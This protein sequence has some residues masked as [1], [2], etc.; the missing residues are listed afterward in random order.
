MWILIAD[1]LLQALS[2]VGYSAQGFADDF[3]ALVAGRN[4]SAVCE[5]M[6]VALKRIERWRIDHGLLVNPDKTEIVLFMRKRILTGMKPILFFVKELTRTDQVKHLGIIL[7]SKLTW[8][9]NLQYNSKK[10][11]ALFWQCR[12]IV[13][14]TWGITPKIAHWIYTTIIRPMLTHGAVV[15]WPRVELRVAR[16]LLSSLQRLAG[17]SIFGAIRTIPTVAMEVLTYLLPLDIHIKLVA[18]STCYRIKSNTSWKHTYD[19]NSH[20][21]VV[22]QMHKVAPVTN[23]EGDRMKACFS[24]EKQYNV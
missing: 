16:T 11:V 6:Q 21:H 1:G 2:S 5:V 12:R 23:M 24:F 20:T 14:K 4:L 7:D 19:P 17:L 9:E 13:G 18:M 10:A 3:S 22:D 8:K 15:W